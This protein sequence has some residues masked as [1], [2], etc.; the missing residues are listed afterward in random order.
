LQQSDR[1]L[2][3]LSAP[4]HF[5]EP[6]ARQ[7]M[8]RR[9]DVWIGAGLIAVLTVKAPLVVVGGLFDLWWTTRRRGRDLRLITRD[10]P[11]TGLTIFGFGSLALIESFLLGLAVQLV[12]PWFLR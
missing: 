7:T 12:S 2:G 5:Y 1:E 10:A 11:L 3:S 9:T 4:A 6:L 8:N